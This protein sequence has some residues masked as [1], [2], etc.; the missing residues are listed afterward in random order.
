[1]KSVRFNQGM[2]QTPAAHSQTSTFHPTFGPPADPD[3]LDKIDSMCGIVIGDETC[4][5]ITLQNGQ[6]LRGCYPA[7]RWYKAFTPNLV[8]LNSLLGTLRHAERLQLALNLASTLLQLHQT[9]WLNDRWTV[10]DIKFFAKTSVTLSQEIKQTRSHESIIDASQPLLANVLS[11]DGSVSAEADL[12][13]PTHPNISVLCLG[14]MLL[15]VYFGH[16][17][18]EEWQ[19]EDLSEGKPNSSTNWS[20]A[21]RW[22]DRENNGMSVRQGYWKATFHCVHC[23]FDPMPQKMDLKEKDFREVLYLSVVLPLEKELKAWSSSP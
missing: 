21:K 4:R 6:V 20:A 17:I 13:A 5:G 14:I 23:F 18:E 9:P 1:M 10:R 15:E 16:T 8:S 22:L 2:G 7:S 12:P 11:H 3:S 19:P